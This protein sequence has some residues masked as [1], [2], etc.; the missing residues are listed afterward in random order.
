MELSIYSIL[1]S[2]P[3]QLLQFSSSKHSESHYFAIPA[4]ILKKIM[5]WLHSI[6]QGPRFS[7]CLWKI[8]LFL[9]LLYICLLYIFSW[10]RKRNYKYQFCYLLMHLQE[11]ICLNIFF[12]QELKTKSVLSCNNISIIWWHSKL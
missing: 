8:I 5:Y 2:G 7:V 1:V 4:V 9:C 10:Y 11:S 12:D 3:N 6:I